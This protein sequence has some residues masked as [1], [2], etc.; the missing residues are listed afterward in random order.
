MKTTV[1]NSQRVFLVSFTTAF[2][3]QNI[4]CNLADIPTVLATRPADKYLVKEFWNG[5]FTRL[6]KKT[7]N[8]YFA[9]NQINVF[10]K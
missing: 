6:S 10:I 8:E 1:D 4:F 2:S 5:K 9:A 3:G 7:L